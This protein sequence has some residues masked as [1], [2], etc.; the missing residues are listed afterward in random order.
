VRASGPSRSKRPSILIKEDPDDGPPYVWFGCALVRPG[1]CD[2]RCPRDARAR[3]RG[4]YSAAFGAD[5]RVG[6]GGGGLPGVRGDGYWARP[7]GP[8]AARRAVFRPGHAAA[9]AGADLAL[10]RT[11]VSNRHVQ[12]GSRSGA[13]A[14]GADRPCGRLGG[15]CTQLRRHHR[16]SARST[17]RGGLAHLLGCDRGGGQGPDQRPSPAERR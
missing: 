8:D 3:R 16:L 1:R 9:L 7:P 15:R 13:A 5:G 10:P 4:R 2:L 17:S 6:S 14:D 11:G 12:R